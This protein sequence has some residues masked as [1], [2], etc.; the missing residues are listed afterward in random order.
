MYVNFTNKTLKTVKKNYLTHN[1][2]YASLYKERFGYKDFKVNLYVNTTL[3]LD[4][5]IE[6][7]LCL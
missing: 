4:E 7:D 3:K 1:Y 5:I 6:F 2:M